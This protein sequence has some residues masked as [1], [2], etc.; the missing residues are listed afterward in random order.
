[1]R[2]ARLPIARFIEAASVNQKRH[3]LSRGR[4]ASR[5]YGLVYRAVRAGKLKPPTE[6]ACVDCGVDAE[7]YDHRNYSAPLVVE[8][9]CFGCNQVRG[10]AI[11][12]AP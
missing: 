4:D 1:M 10:H 11:G 3:G 8:P 9:V 5:A 2:K 7:C 12:A 6:F